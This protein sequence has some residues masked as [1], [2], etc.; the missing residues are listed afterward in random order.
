MDTST[1][2]SRAFSDQ[3]VRLRLRKESRA[4]LYVRLKILRNNVT[5]LSNRGKRPNP[6]DAPE[7]T[8]LVHTNIDYTA[9]YAPDSM[10]RQ[11]PRT[12]AGA[13]RSHTYPG[14]TGTFTSQFA[15]N[16]QFEPFPPTNGYDTMQYSASSYQQNTVSPRLGSSQYQNTPRYTS[17]EHAV[18]QLSSSGMAAQHPPSRLQSMGI[19]QPPLFGNTP[20]NFN[21][22]GLGTSQP[23]IFGS[24][25]HTNTPV[26]THPR[27]FQ[28]NF[29]NPAPTTSA[30]AGSNN[31]NTME[32]FYQASPSQSSASSPAI[33]F[34]GHPAGA[35]VSSRR[36]FQ[37]GRVSDTTVYN[38]AESHVPYFSGSTSFATPQNTGINEGQQATTTS[39]AYHPMAH[40]F[41]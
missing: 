2:L 34:S 35:S 3:G 36:P 5:N 26:A 4:V 15:G 21:T 38:R 13:I 7:P 39:A 22:L 37:D 8:A 27:E 33:P 10:A 11:R 19:S 17:S 18:G 1:Y 31:S 23:Y 25:A 29:G 32:N 12:H 40:V 20:T 14:P 6:Y 16:N 41:Q 30:C 28:E 9:S 24:S